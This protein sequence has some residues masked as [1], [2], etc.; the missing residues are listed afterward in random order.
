M[1]TFA[2]RYVLS[3]LAIGFGLLSMIGAEPAYSFTVEQ[4]TSV[5]IFPKVVNT[6][7]TD[8]V[9]QITNNH[10]MMVHAH[11][12]YTDG[13]SLNGIPRWSVTDFRL[14]LTRQQ[15]TTF[16]ASTGRPVDS[17]DSQT[18]LDPGA[19]PPTTPGFTGSLVCVQ[20]DLPYGGLPS[21]G[22][23]LTGR[24]DVGGSDYNATGLAADP[25]DMGVVTPDNVVDLDGTEYARCP[26]AYHLNFAANGSVGAVALGPAMTAEGI[27]GVG[28]V[29]TSLTIVPC[30]F[31]FGN[32]RPARISVNFN[33]IVN[34][35]EEQGSQGGGDVVCWENL[36]L[37]GNAFD[38]FNTSFGTAVVSASEPV[39]AGQVPPAAPFA[40]V[41]NVLRIG[42]SGGVDTA[43]TNLHAVRGAEPA[44]GQIVLPASF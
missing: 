21:A 43:S 41:A 34:E 44:D 28:Q 38:S 8:T 26:S 25:Q 12:F 39:P 16:S 10:N 19:V 40:A 18:G 5:L 7:E 3:V 23:N 17:T 27:D 1:R 20:M 36:Q 35:F 37:E 11:C 42:G 9:I 32:V 15:T 22:N 29:A 6:D 24:A 13:Q 33:P 2:G 4:P 14:T 31:D 30:D